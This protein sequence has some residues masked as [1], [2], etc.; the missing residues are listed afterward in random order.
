VI[1]S[2]SVIPPPFLL[3]SGR[4]RG[5]PFTF[6]TESIGRPRD[7]TL[8]PFY[9]LHHQRYTIYWKTAAGAATVASSIGR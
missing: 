5:N 1:L 7:V 9:R 4:S 8:I 6:R 3:E 2:S